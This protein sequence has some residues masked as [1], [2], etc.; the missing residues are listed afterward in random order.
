VAFWNNCCARGRRLPAR[1]RVKG[2]ARL[3]HCR[4]C[5]KRSTITLTN[6]SGSVCPRAGYCTNAAGI[7]T[8]AA[9]NT[10]APG[11]TSTFV[12]VEPDLPEVEFY[13]GALLVSFEG[14]GTRQVFP[15]VQ[16]N[17]LN[18]VSPLTNLNA[19][20]PTFAE[21]GIPK[22]FDPERTDQVRCG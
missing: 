14:V 22:F 4:N 1:S 8:A 11:Q 18:S 6:V 10:T 15:A 9:G 2:R 20:A 7:A 16:M 3:C 12:E 19:A 13:Y 21:L 5:H 17:G